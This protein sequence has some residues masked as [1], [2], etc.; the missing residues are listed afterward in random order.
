MEDLKLITKRL[1]LSFDDKDVSLNDINFDELEE[2]VEDGY[3][4]SRRPVLMKYEDGQ[5][6][7]TFSISKEKSAVGFGN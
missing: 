7:I 1:A 2:N 4:L 3:V 5:L 6:L